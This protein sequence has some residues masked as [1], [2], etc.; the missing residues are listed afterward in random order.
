[1]TVSNAAYMQCG[2][3][4]YTKVANGYQVVVLK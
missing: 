2:S 3:T 4:H 1:V